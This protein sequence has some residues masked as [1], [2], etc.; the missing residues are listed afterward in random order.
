MR[1]V[2]MPGCSYA[3]EEPLDVAELFHEN[4]PTLNLDDDMGLE[5]L[6]NGTL[7]HDDGNQFDWDTENPVMNHDNG[8]EGE[9]PEYVGD[10]GDEVAPIPVWPP[11]QTPF[12]CSYC[13]VLRE[14]IHQNG[15]NSM[16]LEI[17]GRIG[18]ICHAIHETRTNVINEPPI[19]N[20][21]MVDFTTQ[22]MDSVKH[23]IV[24]YCQN[25]T[26]EGYV[27]VQDPLWVYYDALCYGLNWFNNVQPDEP[28][29]PPEAHRPRAEEENQTPDATTPRPKPDQATQKRKVKALTLN[30]LTRWFHVTIVQAAKELQ[31]S[32]TAIKHKCREFGVERWPSR[33]VESYNKKILILEKSIREGTSKPNASREMEN[34][35]KKLADIYAC[36]PQRDNVLPAAR[37]RRRTK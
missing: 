17:H 27:L 25:R 31:L 37:G 6:L 10:M 1:D 7:Q 14:I 23:F 36:L 34:L 18:V 24:E 11:V 28:N 12:N 26:Q 3:E 15:A 4:N 29:P 33:T 2:T 20:H 9:N 35:R 8:V 30:D 21:Q 22:S 32:P 13:Q 5:D 19:V 16:K